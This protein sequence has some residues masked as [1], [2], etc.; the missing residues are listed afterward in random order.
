MMAR[1]LPSF[2]LTV[3][4]LILA[5]WLAA[6]SMYASEDHRLILT[7]DSPASINAVPF[8]TYL[9]DTSNSLDPTQPGS[10]DDDIWETGGDQRFLQ[11]GM[12]DAT[13]W[14]R[15]VIDNQ[16][17]GTIYRLLE[18]AKPLIDIVDITVINTQGVEQYHLG[19]M[20]PVAERPVTHR[21]LVVPVT[22]PPGETRVFVR[23]QS[24]KALTFALNLLSRKSLQQTAQQHLFITGLYLGCILFVVLLSLYQ[25]LRHGRTTHCFLALVASG[26]ALFNMI[27]AGYAQ[28]ML[29]PDNQWLGDRASLLSTSATAV[30]G[31]LFGASYLARHGVSSFARRLLLLIALVNGIMFASAMV[32]PY[33]AV[34]NFALVIAVVGLIFT[35]AAAAVVALQR[36]GHTVIFLAGWLVLAA[37]AMASLF[38]LLAWSPPSGWAENG[39]LLGSA[40]APLLWFVA[41]SDQMECEAGQQLRIA[42][43][44]LRQGLQ[45]ETQMQ[46]R[47]Q[48]LLE[49]NRHYELLLQKADRLDATTG[50]L[51]LSAFHEEMGRAHR[52]ALRY[53]HTLTVVALE[54]ADLQT[55]NET[56]GHPAG[57]GCLASV[58]RIVSESLQRPGD[59]AGRITGSRLGIVLPYTNIEGALEVIQRIK[60][61]VQAWKQS[62]ASAPEVLALRAGVASTENRLARH[63]DDLIESAMAQ[64]PQND[65]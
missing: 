49:E 1:R 25:W 39:I 59:I 16:Q 36:G 42:E 52:G 20:Q 63:A 6:G 38:H 22:L 12:A 10:A 32:V 34:I 19:A 37:G 14:I 45:R 33:G 50:L 57:D 11:F 5:L 4:G 9:L 13:Y 64:I 48:H 60:A 51:N 3:P 65:D 17:P 35:A 30:F 54:I 29:W 2:F 27:Q 43:T 56:L 7:A 18:I 44:A 46:S 41:L 21:N 8:A 28:Q 58:A 31:T 55:I 40:L 23:L 62:D 24:A 15:L 47:L 53:G 61:G 26:F